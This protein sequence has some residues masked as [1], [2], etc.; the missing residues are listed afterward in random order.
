MGVRISDVGNH[1]PQT[2]DDIKKCL[3]QSLSL[4][5]QEVGDM[6]MSLPSKL[7]KTV[8]MGGIYKLWYMWVEQIKAGRFLIIIVTEKDD[9]VLGTEEAMERE[10]LQW[11]QENP[12]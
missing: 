2:V 5:P 4:E 10:F 9:G 12:D 6:R 3:F 8:F 7:Q 1:P 11:H